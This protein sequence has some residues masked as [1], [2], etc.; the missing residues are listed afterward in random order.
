VGVSCSLCGKEI[1]L[2]EQHRKYRQIVGWEPHRGRKKGGTNALRMRR[3]TGAV[4]HEECVEAGA[5]RQKAGL[6]FDQE[7][8]F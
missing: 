6:P 3:E 1:L 4:A 7:G 2:E 8:L 5:R